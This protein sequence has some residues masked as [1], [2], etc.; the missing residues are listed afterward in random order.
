MPG[1]TLDVQRHLGSHNI[2]VDLH[3]LDDEAE[4]QYNQMIFLVDFS[5][6]LLDDI[7]LAEWQGLQT[8][9]RKVRSGLWITHGGLLCGRNPNYAS[10]Q[11]LLRGIKT[12][13]RDLR[14]A[15]LDL[16]RVS[17]CSTQ[18]GIE[19]I[20]KVLKKITNSKDPA[21]DLEF[22]QMNGLLFRS[23]LYAD[24]EQNEEYSS[25]LEQSG[26][27]ELLSLSQLQDIPLQLNIEKPSV[28][29]TLSFKE[30]KTFGFPLERDYVEIDVK[31]VGLNN[32]V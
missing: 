31:A 3:Q 12:E 2:S 21:C 29:S 9:I 14:L 22:Q 10:T 27:P 13:K 18:D 17:E 20:F 19:T 5:S 23:S 6:P 4:P 28:L 8:L 30:D 24:A 11:G 7:T 25:R 1:F 26:R 32:K 16:D 15:L